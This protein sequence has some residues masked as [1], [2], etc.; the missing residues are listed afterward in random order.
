[1]IVAEPSG[2]PSGKMF[3]FWVCRVNEMAT[4]RTA[5]TA[6]FAVQGNPMSSVVEILTYNNSC[7]LKQYKR[8]T[9]D[10]RNRGGISEVLG[11]QGLAFL[12]AVGV[13]GQYCNLNFSW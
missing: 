7:E 12:F 9:D 3:P 11:G 6:V 1:M 2:I 8:T 13:T 4:S 5:R 10:E